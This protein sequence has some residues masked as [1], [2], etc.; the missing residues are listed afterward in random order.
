MQLS[1]NRTTG[2]GEVFRK[3]ASGIVFK[4]GDSRRVVPGTMGELCLSVPAIG[5]SQLGRKSELTFGTV[6]KSENTL[7][8]AG[9]AEFEKK[10]SRDSFHGRVRP[11]EGQDLFH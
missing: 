7:L 5:G 10:Q 6:E 2:S 4:W 1:E 11:F 8:G 3:H 9:T